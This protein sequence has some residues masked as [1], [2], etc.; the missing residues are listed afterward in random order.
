MNIHQRIYETIDLDPEEVMGVIGAGDSSGIILRQDKMK[1]FLAGNEWDLDSYK[2]WSR[3]EVFLPVPPLPKRIKHV[4]R[5]LFKFAVRAI[6]EGKLPIETKEN[7][8][9]KLS[10]CEDDCEYY[11]GSICTHIDCGCF[12]KIKTF[13]ETEN[14]PVGKW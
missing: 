13:F 3:G 12:S 11:N 7:A 4:S 9:R 1:R 6:Q 5:A 14:C 2:E 8:Q 10:I